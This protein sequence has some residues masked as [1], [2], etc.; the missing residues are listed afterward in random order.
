MTAR[1]D[2]PMRGRDIAASMYPTLKSESS[3]RALPPYVPHPGQRAAIA[4]LLAGRVEYVKGQGWKR[5][6]G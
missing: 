2:D 4:D 1:S 5:K 3:N 6:G